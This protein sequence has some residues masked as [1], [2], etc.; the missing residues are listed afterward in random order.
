MNNSRNLMLFAVSLVL[1]LGLVGCGTPSEA[2]PV[3]TAPLAT[4][5]GTT[6]T[7]T[8]SATGVE[9]I[10]LSSSTINYDGPTGQEGGKN[11]MQ[12]TLAVSADGTIQSVSLVQH[13]EE[14]KSKQLQKSF[15]N[16]I[17]SH[18]VGQKLESASIGT[19]GGASNTSAAFTKALETLKTQ[20]N[21]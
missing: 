16:A 14:P 20:F 3:E 2:T 15:E 4:E 13:G 8:S 1:S 6:T 11:T 5:T 18:L 17:S 10:E 21:A 7:E 9:V 12:A 19:L